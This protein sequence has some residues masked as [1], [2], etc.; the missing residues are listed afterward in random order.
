MSDTPALGRTYC[1][2][3][4]PERDPTAELLDARPCGLHSLAQGIDDGLVTAG[5]LGYAEC[6]GDDNRE[7]CRLIHQERR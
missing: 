2:G 1:P 5:V 6:G 4:E 3:C 7:W